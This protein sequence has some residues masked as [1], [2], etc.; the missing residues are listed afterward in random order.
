MDVARSAPQGA[1]YH[2]DVI[3]HAP[4]TGN[5]ETY[6]NT[7]PDQQS[8]YPGEQYFLTQACTALGVSVSCISSKVKIFNYVQWLQWRLYLTHGVGRSKRRSCYGH[9][10]G[11]A[12]LAPRYRCEDN[13]LTRAI[14]GVISPITHRALDGAMVL[15]DSIGLILPCNTRPPSTGQEISLAN[16]KVIQAPKTCYLISRGKIRRAAYLVLPHS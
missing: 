13:N 5:K 2:A 14:E 12:N 15:T 3:Y 4:F 1:H 7:V 8:L 11:G 10:R 6:T 9:V 16:L